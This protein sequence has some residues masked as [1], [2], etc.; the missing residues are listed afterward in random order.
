[1]I[2]QAQPE[3]TL[4]TDRRQVEV[5]GLNRPGV[6]AGDAEAEA[7]GPEEPEPTP[8]GESSSSR[9]WETFMRPESEKYQY[10][11]MLTQE[12]QA[13]KDPA[14]QEYLKARKRRFEQLIEANRN[15]IEAASKK[16]D[17]SSK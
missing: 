10:L 4:P 13:E 15:L 6:F 8:A 17:A 11:A 14:K 1:M 3:Y 12:L 7:Y 2:G 9:P 16:L 5:D